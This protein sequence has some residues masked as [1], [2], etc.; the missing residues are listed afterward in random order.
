MP[1]EVLKE[2]HRSGAAAL[3]ND[4][5]LTRPW[6]DS[7]ADF[8]RALAGA[9]STVLGCC[10]DGTVIGTVMVGHDGHRG[11]I[12]YMAVAPTHQGKGVGTE[13]MSGAEEWLRA[14][15]AVKVQL[16]VRESNENVVGFY[17]RRGYEDSPVMVLSKRLS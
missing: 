1:V 17:E 4:V 13:L 14:H 2:M 10:L 9:T 11:W 7:F 8:D 5:G 15:G 3:W 6:N 16:M 12:Y